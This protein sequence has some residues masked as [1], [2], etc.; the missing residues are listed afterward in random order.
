MATAGPARD[1]NDALRTPVAADAK[2][3]AQ[4]AD[5]II[6]DVMALGWPVGTFLGTE[7][8]LL[9]RYSVSR[10]VFREAVRLIEHQQVARTRRGPGGGLRITEPT[11][12]AVVEAVVLYLHRVDARLDEVVEARLVLEELATRLACERADEPERAA[13]RDIARHTQTDLSDARGLHLLLARASKNLA[14]ELF[15]GVLDETANLYSTNWKAVG[16]GVTTDTAHAHARIAE[17]VLAGE[18]DL[19]SRRMRKHL[20]AEAA[21]LRRRRST[22]Q[23]LP[24]AAVLS[25][26]TNG[27]RAEATARR[28]T[29][30]LVTA[31]LQPGELVGA[32]SDLMVRTG[33][34]RAVLREAVRLLEHHG[35]ARMR[36]G[37]GGGLFVAEPNPFAVTDVAAIYLA[38]HGMQLDDLSEL[39]TA[40]EASLAE[41]A[42][43]RAGDGKVEALE[44]ALHRETGGNPDDVHDVHTVVASMA[45]N[46][47]LE[48][49][50]LVLIRLSRIRQIERVPAARRRQMAAEV[51]RA[52]TA[53]AHAVTR[54]DAQ[55]ARHRMQRHLDALGAVTRG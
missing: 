14:L 34:S 8:E 11:T 31:K 29:H 20:E 37:P 55:V 6:E 13:L 25:E 30:E 51:H 19:A 53:I 16:K 41:M 48:L 4:V 5:Q 28:I 1:R 22:R 42:A 38:R 23:Q 21:Y 33:V 17:A 9:E 47:A 7:A 46:R 52:H 18:P 24:T 50:A 35:V 45:G 40:V 39:R 44:E 10:A 49:V 26:M 2:R 43:T 54:G 36:R 27:K 3:S 12:D 15:V 32:E